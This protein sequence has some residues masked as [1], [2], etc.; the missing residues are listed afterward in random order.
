MKDFRYNLSIERLSINDAKTEINKFIS[1]GW[2]Y[3]G[4]WNLASSH[5]FAQL[6][7]NKSSEPIYPQEY[8]KHTNSTPVKADGFL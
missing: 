4:N 5:T 8:E 2:T 3:I 7:W 1:C 6:A